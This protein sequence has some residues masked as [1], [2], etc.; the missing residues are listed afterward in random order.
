[1]FIGNFFEKT[2]TKNLLY[3]KINANSKTCI[4]EAP[5]F[6]TLLQRAI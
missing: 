5:F 2:A 4:R 1:M 3:L 6:V